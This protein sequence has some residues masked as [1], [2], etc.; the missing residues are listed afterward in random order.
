MKDLVSHHRITIVASTSLLLLGWAVF[1]NPGR[2]WPGILS[3]A[4]LAAVL[5]TCT[6]VLLIG[7]LR[8]PAASMAQIIQDVDT[9]TEPAASPSAD[10]KGKAIL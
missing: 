9:D 10:W 5:V 3:V 6:A 8:G 4:A 1:A 2:S 7:R